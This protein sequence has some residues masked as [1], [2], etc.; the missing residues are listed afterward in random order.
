MINLDVTAQPGQGQLLGN[1]LCQVAGLL[2]NPL[3]GLLGPGGALTN[4]L[5]GVTNLLGNLLNGLLG[6]LGGIVGK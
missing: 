1:L 6:G 5:N 3:G 2:D 4:L